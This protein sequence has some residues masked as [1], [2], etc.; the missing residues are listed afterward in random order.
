MSLH[1]FVKHDMLVKH[2]LPL[3][4][5][6]KKL[7]NLSHLNSDTQVRQIWIHLV[8]AC[9]KY[10]KRRYKNMHHWSGWTE[11]ATEN[12]V[13]QAESCRH[14]GNH[15][16]VASLIAPGQLCMFCTPSLAIFPTCCYQL[17]SNWRIWRPQ[18]QCDKF[19]NFFW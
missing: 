5:Y 1:Y 12:R 17:D 11:T 2:V 18:L 6:R 7:Q 4:C 9:E 14:C 3:S 13:G 10:C 15:L 8:T 19:W 16:S